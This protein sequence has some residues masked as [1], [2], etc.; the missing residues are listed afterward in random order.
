MMQIGKLDSLILGQEPCTDSAD[1]KALQRSHDSYGLTVTIGLIAMTP[2][3]PS[4]AGDT[5]LTGSSGDR[6]ATLTQLHEPCTLSRQRTTPR[7]LLHSTR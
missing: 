2:V 1:F 6:P 3:I 5:D 4:T 7:P